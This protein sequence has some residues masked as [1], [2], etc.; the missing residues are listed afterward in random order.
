LQLL[1]GAAPP[2]E[3]PW[4]AEIDAAAAHEILQVLAPQYRAA[5]TLRYL[6]D[7]PVATVAALLGRTVQATEAVLVRARVAFRRAYEEGEASE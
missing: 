3:D 5:L 7:L 6:D 4:E 1:T 2:F